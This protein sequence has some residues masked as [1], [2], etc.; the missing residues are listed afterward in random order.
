MSIKVPDDVWY[1]IARFIRRGELRKLYSVNRTFFEIAMDER[2]REV[3]FGGLAD[4]K[5]LRRMTRVR[6]SNFDY[7]RD[8]RAPFLNGITQR[9]LHSPTHSIYCD[10]VASPRRAVSG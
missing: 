8:I 4:E 7:L 5:S 3:T 9:A 10:R 2:Y 1:H 6:Y